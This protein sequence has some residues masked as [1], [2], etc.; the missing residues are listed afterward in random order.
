MK[1][2]GHT[3]ARFLRRGGRAVTLLALLTLFG[4]TV[5]A[6]PLDKDPAKLPLEQA[7]KKARVN[8][9]YQMLLR[10]FKV[11]RDKNRYKGFRDLGSREVTEYE[12]QK[13]LPKGHWVYV[14]PYWYIWR[15]LSKDAQN[16]A[17]RNWGPEQATGKPDT[18]PQQGDIITAWASQTA[19]GQREW[20]LLEYDQPLV[21][22]EIH[23]Y[24]TFNPGAVDRVTA[25]KLDGEEVEIW[26]GNDP[27][28]AGSGKG[29]SKIPYKAKFKTNRI[30]IYLDSPGVQGWNEIDAVGLVDKKGKTYWAMAAEASSFFGQ[31]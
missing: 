7:L 22:T 27:T 11:D 15:D 3:P 28:M 31:Q 9:K 6:V 26:K 1:P 25:F 21:P 8:G 10:Q 16:M 30:K 4:A 24:E 13:D 20:L 14:Y 23:I 12:G 5:S 18:W 17:K 2:S 19:D 29:I